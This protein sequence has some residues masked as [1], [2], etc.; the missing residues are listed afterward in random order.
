MQDERRCLQSVRRKKTQNS[1]DRLSGRRFTVSR[2]YRSFDKGLVGDVSYRELNCD[3]LCNTSLEAMITARDLLGALA[4]KYGF[5]SASYG[6]KPQA[7]NL[8]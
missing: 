3:S 6:S 1:Y 8:P 4:V 2:F 7:K 5:N